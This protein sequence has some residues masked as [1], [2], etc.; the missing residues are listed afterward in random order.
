MRKIKIFLLLLLVFVVAQPLD[1]NVEVLENES[2]VKQE[3]NFNI[4]TTNLGVNLD[5]DLPSLYNQTAPS[6]VAVLNYGTN[7]SGEALLQSMGSGVIYFS[8]MIS[9]N[10][11]YYVIT[12]E[13]VIS[14]S[15]SLKVITYDNLIKDAILVGKDED[16]DIAVLMINSY[17]ISDDYIATLA[18]DVSDLKPLDFVY[19]IGSPSDVILKGTLTVGIVSH[20]GR[21]TSPETTTLY[22][23][24]HSIQID[25]ALN[26]GN[27]GGPL[28]NSNGE[29]I[30]INTYKIKTTGGY[31]FEGLNFSLPIH[32]VYLGV[33][34]IR[35]SA[36]IKYNILES[37]FSI[38]TQGK[39]YKPDYGRFELNAL[40]KLSL[41]EKENLKI[42]I[43]LK[44]GVL[45]GG[46]AV[47][48]AFGKVSIPRYSII[49]EV[50]GE[51]VKD[52]FDVRKILIKQEKE[53]SIEIKYYAPT[54]DGYS[55]ELVS[56]QLIPNS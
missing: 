24:A 10:K 27:S 22:K 54:T 37:K 11:V 35:N 19:A 4:I 20:G 7:N 56:A 39:F 26:P 8:N 12:N 40:Y 29:V 2:I 34:R 31:T 30:G 14:G 9:L 48:S 5:Y 32:D 25:L 6:V 23:Q 16:A 13:H 3:T 51:V 46:V 33:E 18:S 36:N 55:S 38:E 44:Q 49:V 21:N 17:G 43:H 15:A 1:K 53:S 50:D 28:F 41:K 45:L 42:P 52:V 47:A